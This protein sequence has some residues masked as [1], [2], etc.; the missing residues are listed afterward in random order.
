MIDFI[1]WFWG[2]CIYILQVLGG[3]PGDAT[4]P[5]DNVHTEPEELIDHGH[6]ILLQPTPQRCNYE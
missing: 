5:F 6:P 2:I 1:N 4:K 3:S